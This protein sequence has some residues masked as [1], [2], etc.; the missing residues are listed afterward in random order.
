M[1]KYLD[2]DGV[3]YFWQKCKAKFALITHTHTKNQITDFPTIPS[4]TSDLTNDSG[5]VADAS[6]VHTDN[7][8]TSTEKTKLSGIATGAEVNVQ[9]DWNQTNTSADD[10]IKNKPTI[11]DEIYFATYNTTTF[12]DVLAAINAGKLPVVKVSDGASNP[13][14][15]TY[16]LGDYNNNRIAFINTTGA[17]TALNYVNLTSQNVW[18]MSSTG[19]AS[20]DSN[21][22]IPS[23]QLPS[24]HYGVCSTASAQAAKTV[25]CPGFTLVTGAWIIVKFTYEN[26][27]TWSSVTLNVN[28][29]GAKSIKYMGNTPTGTL[30][31]AQLAGS[32]LMFV[33]DGTNYEFVGDICKVRS[34][35]GDAENSYRTG[36]VN[37]TAANIGAVATSVV[38][39]ANGVCPLNSSSKIDSTYLPSYV[40]DVIEA[41]PRSGQTE[42][43]STW[44]STTSGGSALTP[45]TGKI[46]VLMAD[47]TSYAAN[48]QFRWGGSAYVKLADGGVSA[49]TNAEI[50][51]ICV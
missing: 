18:S 30:S 47:S 51:T 17:R 4:K 19:I 31:A 41:Y 50:D 22:L 1:A 35:K 36:H 13:T 37:L 20:L 44:L 49:I 45:E 28:N 29:T 39:Q 5:F 2:Y 33:Y 46:Y 21:G 24:I 32:V 27:Y 3:L 10:Y 16:V 48:S 25:D 6:Y 23:S 40:D 7:N 14:W 34:I 12:S 26:T 11:E 43:S 8:Y 9:S 38:G 42:L 15:T